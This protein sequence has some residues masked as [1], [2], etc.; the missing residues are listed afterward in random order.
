MKGKM[1]D[2]SCLLA[3]SYRMLREPV[4]LYVCSKVE[5]REDAEDLVQ[6]VFLRLCGMKVRVC[7]ETVRNLVF[8]IARNLVT[9]YLRR[10]YR[11]REAVAYVCESRPV[12]VHDVES[13]IVAEELQRLFR[14]KVSELP[15]RRREVYVLNHFQGKCSAEIARQLNL[16]KRTVESHLLLSRGEVRAYM[17]QFV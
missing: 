13:C 9:D 12:S 5:S 14:H 2:L 1:A 4:L 17:K 16:S 6:E 3:D 10:L 11:K 8:A 7:A 15:A